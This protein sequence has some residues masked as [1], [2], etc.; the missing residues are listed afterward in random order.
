MKRQGKGKGKKRVKKRKRIKGKKRIK[1]GEEEGKR[2]GTFLSAER[3][4][5]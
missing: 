4:E 2:E 3:V 5:V 1:E